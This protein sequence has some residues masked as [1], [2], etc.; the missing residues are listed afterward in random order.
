[1]EEII[2]S[3]LH[4]LCNPLFV[5]HEVFY[6]IT[7]HSASYAQ[8]NLTTM[9]M[10]SN[11]TAIT[12]RMS[13]IMWKTLRRGGPGVAGVVVVYGPTGHRTITNRLRITRKLKSNGLRCIVSPPSKLYETIQVEQPKLE[14][15]KQ[16]TA[17]GYTTTFQGLPFNTT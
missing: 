6:K 13:M 7:G 10:I 4:V 17:H 1:M 8:T 3:G 5:L 14:P 9:K 2:S 12:V 15:G 16:N 11:T